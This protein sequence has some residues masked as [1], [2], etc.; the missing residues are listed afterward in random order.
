MMGG[1]I[2]ALARQHMGRLIIVGCDHFQL[3]S[4]VTI[5]VNEQEIGFQEASDA[6]SIPHAQL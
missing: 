3:G 4:G 2:Q 6:G 1:S 5:V